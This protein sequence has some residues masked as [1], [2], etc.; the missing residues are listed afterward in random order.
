MTNSIVFD[1]A[2]DFYDQTRGFPPGQAPN[3]AALLVRA[4]GLTP[5]SRVLEIGI[6]TGRIALPL[7]PHVRAVYGVDLSCLM[8][9]RL[10]AKRTTEPVH[11]AQADATRLPFPDRAFDA[12]VA[13]HVFHLIPNWQDVVCEL[14][15]VLRPDGVLLHG[16]N[17]HGDE[18]KALTDAWDTAVPPQERPEVGVPWQR[19]ETFLLDLGWREVGQKQVIGFTEVR[20][21]QSYLDHR[22]ERKGSN[23]W[24][25]SD[26]QIAR[27]LAA[28]QAV[29]DTQFGGD[30]LR[31][32]EVHN[33]FGVRVFRPPT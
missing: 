28:M 32:V 1:R 21:P 27:G 16:W 17:E 22:R 31:P 23:T 26:E 12:A 4:G 19:R 10:R 15:R 20:T 29:I 3:V 11:L 13:V 30:A 14:T 9:D 2:A 6:G 8:M 7:A 24:R 25:L 33:G 18:F 5:A